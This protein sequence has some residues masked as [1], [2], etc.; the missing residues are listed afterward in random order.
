M[1]FESNPGTS[2]ELVASRN[3]LKLKHNDHQFR[4]KNGQALVEILILR[5]RILL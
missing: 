1:R 5:N 3:S 2:S 4:S